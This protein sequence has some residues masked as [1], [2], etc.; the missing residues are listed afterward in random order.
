MHKNSPEVIALRLK[1]EEEV[2]RKINKTT[3][4]EYLVN[5][6]WERTHKHISMSTLKRM[7]GYVEGYDGVSEGSLNVLSNFIG[8]ESWAHFAGSLNNNWES[9]SILRVLDVI[10]CED[11]EIGDIITVG[12]L[13]NRL[14]KLKYLGNNKH[15]VVYEENSK[16]EVGDTFTCAIFIKNEPMYADNLVRQGLNLTSYIAGSKNGITLLEKH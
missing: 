8:Y 4:F 7:W 9:E 12:W 11:V 16:L 15:E 10:R 1:V 3:D 13:P 5:V 2:S 14:C 6:I